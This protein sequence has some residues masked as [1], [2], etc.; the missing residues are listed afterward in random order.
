M[1]KPFFRKL[2]LEELERL[3]LPNL[4][5]GQVGTPVSGLPSSN[6]EAPGLDGSS[7]VALNAI[8]KSAGDGQANNGL[9]T[10]ASGGHGNSIAI[11]GT[12]HHCCSHVEIEASALPGSAKIP[13]ADAVQETASASGEFRSLGDVANLAAG[14]DSLVDNSFDSAFPSAKNATLVLAGGGDSGMSVGSQTSA[15]A[16]ALGTGSGTLSGNT[17]VSGGFTATAVGSF[18]LTTPAQNGPMILLP[19]S[20][21][22]SSVVA[23]FQKASPGSPQISPAVASGPLHQE[24]L[25]PICLGAPAY[26][27][28]NADNDNGSA[29]TN[30]I[31]TQRDFSVNPLSVNDPE[32]LQATLTTSGLPNTGTWGIT[33]VTTPGAG[34]IAL[35]TDQRK[36]AEFFAPSPG[37]LGPFNFYIEGV[38]ESKQL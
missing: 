37:Q 19:A 28:V 30:G 5:F 24:C 14:F 2:N 20:H 6:S 29:V 22:S 15:S 18:A 8:T 26:V 27:P 35:W 25:D 1:R 33:I 31:P 21:P 3:V 4:F 34:N 16:A 7:L 23:G 11:S 9:L 12:G 10:H 32:L 36:S 13:N 17:G 38:H